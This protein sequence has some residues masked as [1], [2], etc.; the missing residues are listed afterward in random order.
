M[1]NHAHK[2][3]ANTIAHNVRVNALADAC[4]H[5]AIVALGVEVK[6]TGGGGGLLAAEYQ[7]GVFGIKTLEVAR[8]LAELAGDET[9]RACDVALS[10]SV[11]GH[12]WA[13]HVTYWIAPGRTATHGPVVVGATDTLLGTMKVVRFVVEVKRWAREKALGD[14]KRRIEGAGVVIEE[15][16]GGVDGEV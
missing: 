2:S 4:S 14:W 10:L 1:F 12:V 5:H 8:Q 16:A 6:P 13:L 7:L 11:C 3:L 15:G 9:Q